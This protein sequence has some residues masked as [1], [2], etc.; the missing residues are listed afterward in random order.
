MKLIFWWY[1]RKPL[2]A[3]RSRVLLFYPTPPKRAQ[4]KISGA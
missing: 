3:I 4:W 1:H 2:N